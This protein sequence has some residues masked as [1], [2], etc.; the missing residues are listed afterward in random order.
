MLK[1]LSL[2]SQ[3]KPRTASFALGKAASFAYNSPLFNLK[4]RQTSR[5][6]VIDMQLGVSFVNTCDIP[7][8]LEF[9]QQNYPSVLK[10]QCF[11][12]K[13][14]PFAV[15][16]NETEIGHLFEH[17]LIDNLCSLKIKSGAKKASFNGT[18]SWNWQENPRGFFQIWID[19]GREDLELL[20]SALKQT[21]NLTSLLIQPKF[22]QDSAGNLLSH[23]Q[24]V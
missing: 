4:I 2:G 10:T 14:L 9:L 21:I 15:E 13:N 19:I 3:A 11:N 20:I 24:L 16:V 23:P 6:T 18:T 7:G 17:L 5:V 12:E 1:V 22:V 8:T